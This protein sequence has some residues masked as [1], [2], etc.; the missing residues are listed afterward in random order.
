MYC[1]THW[2]LGPFRYFLYLTYYDFHFR[3]SR[4]KTIIFIINSL[5][6]RYISLHVAN[7]KSY[8]R[9]NLSAD[10]NLTLGLHPRGVMIQ[11][12]DHRGR[13]LDTYRRHQ[14]ELVKDFEPHVVVLQLGSNELF[15]SQR[16]GSD[17]TN[18]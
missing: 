12:S 4:N 6:Y 1:N 17:F 8:I 7:L 10:V 9:R 3:H 14:L 15:N 2:P 11:Y 5:G 16:S 13:S 18:E